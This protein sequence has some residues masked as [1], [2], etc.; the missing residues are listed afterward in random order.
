VNREFELVRLLDRESSTPTPDE[1][2]RQHAVL[3]AA[4]DREIHPRHRTTTRL[5]RVILRALAATIAV[6]GLGGT[7]AFAWSQLAPDA[8]RVATVEQHYQAALPVHRP[9]WRPE[10]DAEHVVCDYTG[11]GL[12]T[13]TVYT[14]ASEFPLT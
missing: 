5:T 13:T 10:L 2:A 14:Y 7:A 9:G 11:L 1:I 6:V 8:K 12:A 4:I 3:A